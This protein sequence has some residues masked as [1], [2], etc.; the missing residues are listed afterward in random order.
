MAQFP[1]PEAP[2]AAG[3]ITYDTEAYKRRN[4]VERS[5]NVFKQRRAL[6]T[7]YDKLAYRGGVILARHHHLAQGPSSP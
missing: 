6:A 7:R 2:K 5:F 4:V 1:S 3:P